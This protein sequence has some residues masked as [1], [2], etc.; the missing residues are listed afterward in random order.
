MKFIGRVRFHTF[1]KLTQSL[2]FGSFILLAC[3]I[4]SLT[5]ANSPL[6]DW[7]H[8]ILTYPLG[9]EN[10]NVQ[11]KLSVEQ[12]INDGLMAIF[13]LLVGAEIKRELID[14][15]L[16]D[17]KKASLPILAAFGGAITPAIIYTI[18]NIGG[19]TAHGWGIPMAT[20]IAFALAAISLLGKSVPPSLKV[21]LAA[22]AIIDDLMAIFVIAIFYTSDMNFSY[23]FYAGILTALLVI[24]N[25]LRISKLA[26]YLVPGVLI[27]YF[28]LHSGVHA[29]IAGVIVAFTIPLNISKKESPIRYLE[30]KIDKFVN[31]LIIPVFALANTNIAYVE[32][33]FSGLF[34]KLGL[35]IMLGLL[36]GKV[37]G[38]TLTC[39]LAVKSKIGI[40]PD[41]AS[42]KHMI[43]LGLLAGIGF[44]MSIFVSLL[45]F[46]KNA[47]YIDEAKFSIL[48]TSVMAGVIGYWVLKLVSKG[49]QYSSPE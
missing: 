11:L 42:W 27:W 30:T 6:H 14:G 41:G 3:V 28:I 43:G 12:W 38:I 13:F 8:S 10:Q 35:G 46:G 24:F 1:K 47:E 2:Y 18:I 25:R 33:M 23:L 21:F 37:V 49:K 20:D 26:F 15:E 17:K 44:T 4:L 7:F 39:F 9:F 16:S 32:G 45:S 48:V 19:D 5:I 22:L 29:T 34:T 36:V 40:L 31:F